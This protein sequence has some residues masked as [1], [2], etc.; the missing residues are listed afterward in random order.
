MCPEDPRHFTKLIQI[1]RD[2]ATTQPSL[3]ILECCA[4]VNQYQKGQSI[5]LASNARGLTAVITLYPPTAVVSLIG[6]LTNGQTADTG[7]HSPDDRFSSAADEAGPSA[8]HNLKSFFPGQK[9]T[10]N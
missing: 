7:D 3:N 5:I 4:T 6:D 8:L 1:M 10:V 2:I 9:T